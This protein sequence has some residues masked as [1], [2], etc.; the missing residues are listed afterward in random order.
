MTPAT[1]AAESGVST[2]AEAATDA[3]PADLVL[4]EVFGFTGY[5]PGQQE[6]VSAMMAR[7]D[8]LAIMPTGGGKSLCYQLPGIAAGGLTLVVSPLVALMEDQVS[9]LRAAGVEAGAFTAGTPEDERERIFGAIEAGVLRLLYVAPERLANERFCAFLQRLPIRRLAVDE[10][11]CISQWGHDFRP[12]YLRL[13]PLAATLGVPVGAFTATAD[14]ETRREILARLFPERRPRVFLR[15]F[16]RPN[17]FLA[18]EPKQG[19]DRQI[20]D[21]VAARRGQCGIVYAATRN[22]T[23]KLADALVRAGV[24]A[25]AYHAG[26]DPETREARQRAFSR[27]DDMVMVATVAF[28]MGV[29]KP[30]VR[31]VV[32]ADLP[33]SIESYYQEIGRAGRDGL[34]AETSCFYGLDDIRLAR[35][36]IDE[37]DAPEDRKRADH[38]RLNALLALA[39]TPGC[40]RVPLLAYFGDLSEPCGNCDNC[41]RPPQTIDGTEP[42]QMALSAM[43]RSGERFGMGHVVAILRGVEDERIRRLGHDRLKTFGVGQKWSDGAWKGWLRQLFAQGLCGID[44]ERHGAWYVTEAGW[45]VLKGGREV[46]LRPAEAAKKGTSGAKAPKPVLAG[47]DAPLFEAM[48]ALRRELAAEAGVPPYVVFSD[49]TLIALAEARPTTPEAMASVDGVGRVKLQKFGEAFLEI[50]RV[51]R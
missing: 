11:H 22:R 30:D 12:D 45:E 38:A 5:R 44:G 3:S 35:A 1:A 13:G 27:S 41:R 10:A 24:P 32:E 43:V 9:A 39:E 25:Q 31:F 47:D 14:E 28:G 20:V 46:V 18:F 42:A 48:R 19:G 8:V 36:R 4:R 7:E 2:Q 34:A 40:R 29:D 49:R 37:G 51:H 15:G 23:E 16:D 50:I 21:F 6:I 33:K 17:L 26:L